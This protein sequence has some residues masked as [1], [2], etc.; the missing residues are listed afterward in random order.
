MI[1]YLQNYSHFIQIISFLQKANLFIRSNFLTSIFTPFTINWEHAMFCLTGKWNHTRVLIYIY[2][3]NPH[4]NTWKLFILI[5]IFILEY[6]SLLLLSSG[7]SIYIHI[8]SSSWPH[9]FLINFHSN[10]FRA[11]EKKVMMER[12]L[13]LDTR[14]QYYHPYF[15]HRK[16]NWAFVGDTKSGEV[17]CKEIIFMPPPE[18]HYIS[19]SGNISFSQ[20]SR[21][22]SPLPLPLNQCHTQ[23][24]IT[25]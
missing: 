5:R 12:S 16:K 2:V 18:M 22:T 8:L 25:S 1:I 19:Q 23:T 3:I 10:A 13:T 9:N 15:V 24:A 17:R 7:I 4:N 11:K 21:P 20:S 6:F 14:I